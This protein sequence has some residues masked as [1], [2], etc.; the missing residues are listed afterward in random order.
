[1]EQLL[2]WLTKIGQLVITYL[3]PQYVAGLDKSLPIWAIGLG[4]AVIMA[5][6][7]K[8]VTS[9]IFKIILWGALIVIFFIILQSFNVPVFDI[10]TN[11]G[12]N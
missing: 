1:M 2:D 3:P 4:A 6:V 5:F 12:N 7:L 10:L 9:L 8:I 11:L